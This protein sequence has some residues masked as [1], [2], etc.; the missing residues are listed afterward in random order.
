MPEVELSGRTRRSQLQLHL[1]FFHSHRIVIVIIRWLLFSTHR[2]FLLVGCSFSFTD[3]CMHVIY[4][5]LLFIIYYD[6]GLCI[7]GV[8]ADRVQVYHSYTS[9]NLYMAKHMCEFDRISS[10]L[11]ACDSFRMRN[12]FDFPLHSFTLLWLW[13]CSPFRSGSFLLHRWWCY[14]CCWLCRW[15]YWIY[16]RWHFYSLFFTTS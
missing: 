4:A 14:C 5:Y 13:K 10:V 8:V 7:F 12:I 6:W 3:V 11:I 16:C 2:P 1:H 9:R 15:R